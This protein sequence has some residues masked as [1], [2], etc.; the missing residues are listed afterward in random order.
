MTFTKFCHAVFLGC[1][2]ALGM[3][4]AVI[5]ITDCTSEPVNPS[6]S[7]VRPPRAPLNNPS[8]KLKCQEKHSK[9]CE[10]IYEFREH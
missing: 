1:L 5:Y 2:L 3:A 4:A 7:D 6:H 8:L 9:E 10:D